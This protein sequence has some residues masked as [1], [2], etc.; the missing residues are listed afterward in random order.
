VDVSTQWTQS[1]GERSRRKREKD[2]LRFVVLLDHLPT[3][4]LRT[5][6][7]GEVVFARDGDQRQVR[8]VRENEAAVAWTTVQSGLTTCLRERKARNVRPAKQQKNPGTG[9][10]E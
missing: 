1:S 5:V 2:T 3:E 4:A 9:N 7:Y 10:T 8:V 6:E